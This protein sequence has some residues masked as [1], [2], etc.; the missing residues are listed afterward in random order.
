MENHCDGLKSNMDRFIAFCRV[1]MFSMF[2]SLKS[3]MD[4]F[5]ES[6]TTFSPT[7]GTV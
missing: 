2:S 6:A 7:P 1:S 5:I 3:N 4:R